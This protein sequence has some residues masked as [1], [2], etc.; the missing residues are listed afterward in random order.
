MSAKNKKQRMPRQSRSMETKE[1][2]LEAAQELFS[3]K[4]FFRT[5]SKEIAVKAKVAVGS[6]Y[7][8]FKDKKAV[9]MELLQIHNRK[10]SDSIFLFQNAYDESEKNEKNFLLSMIDNVIKAHDSQPD[11]HKD[12]DFLIYNDRDIK[13]MM[14]EFNEIT[15]EKTKELLLHFKNKLRIKDLDA[16]AL[17]I[18]RTIEDI[19]HAIKY[20]NE[21]IEKERLISELADMLLLYLFK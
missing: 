19:V 5:N 1:N 8:Y 9:L 3:K 15:F 12:I 18:N 4:G 16:A 13:N 7:A 14:K 20:D 6:F 2:I 10:I 21:P 11:F 17:L